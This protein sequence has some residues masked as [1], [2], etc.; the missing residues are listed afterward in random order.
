[1]EGFFPLF[2]RPEAGA[3]RPT[4]VIFDCETTGIDRQN[5]QIIELCIQRGL[6]DDQDDERP[7]EVKTWRLKPVAPIHPQAQAVHGIALEDLEACP[8][9]AEVAEEI[10][11]AFAAAD[12]V[13]GYNIAFDIEMLQAEYARCGKPPLDFSTKIIVDALRLWQQ[14][15]PRSLQNAHQRFVGNAFEAAHT[16]SADVA[17]TGRVLT[18][19]LRA[20]AL[21]GQNWQEIATKGD[22]YSR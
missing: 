13:V 2:D 16:A 7:V 9:F 18:G 14:F 21:D 1:V 22:P 12:V 19:M 3:D 11:A 15:E 8:G 20:F 5:D 4:V 17:A 10:A 6:T